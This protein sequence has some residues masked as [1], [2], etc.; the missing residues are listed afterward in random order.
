MKNLLIVN[1]DICPLLLEM[2]GKLSESSANPASG[3]MVRLCGV[4]GNALTLKSGKIGTESK[5]PPC[6]SLRSRAAGR[7]LESGP[8]SLSF[9][10]LV[11]K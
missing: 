2:L 10:F 4:L 6:Y 11:C 3:A 1:H 7:A 5:Y 8:A 9:R